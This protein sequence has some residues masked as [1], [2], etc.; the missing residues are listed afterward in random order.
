MTQITHPI[1]PAAFRFVARELAVDDLALISLRRHADLVFARSLFCWL[2]RNCAVEPPSYPQIGRYLGG[3][4]H[5][6]IMHLEKVRGSKLRL[7]SQPF[8]ALCDDFA[9]HQAPIVQVREQ[10]LRQHGNERNIQWH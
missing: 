6:S 4:H 8:K 2:A 1:L 7:W 3:R 10:L 5:T 9:V